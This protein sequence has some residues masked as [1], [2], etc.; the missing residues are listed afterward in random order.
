GHVGGKS[1]TPAWLWAWWP[2]GS[3][4]I[5]TPEALARRVHAARWMNRVMT[6]VLGACLVTTVGPLFLILGYL[7]FMGV[8]AVDWNFFVKLPAPEG[9]G[10][11]HALLGS[12]MLV[13]TATLIAVPIGLL[14]AIYLS[15]YSDRWLAP[16]VRFVGELL[17]G[18]PSI[19][20]GIFAYAVV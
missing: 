8:G 7:V 12:A 6:A 15:E 9:G 5:P 20:I 17:G 19:V 4:A 14:A 18:V 2:K 16:A 3:Q 13:G 11:G 10:L 1:W